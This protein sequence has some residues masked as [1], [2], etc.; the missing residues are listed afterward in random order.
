MSHSAEGSGSDIQAEK[1]KPATA[2]TN[3][4]FWGDVQELS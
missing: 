2:I 1:G 4:T 3:V